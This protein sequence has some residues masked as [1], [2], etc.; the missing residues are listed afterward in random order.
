M[1]VLGMIRFTP[2]FTIVVVDLNRD[3]H[4]GIS[5]EV[6]IFR[7]LRR[8]PLRISG[9]ICYGFLAKSATGRLRYDS[10]GTAFS[11][12]AMLASIASATAA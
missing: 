3:P 5:G 1:R 2:G 8:N 6:V 12:V 10:S 4:F 9:E 7:D 11:N